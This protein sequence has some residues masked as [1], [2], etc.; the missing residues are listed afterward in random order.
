[1]TDINKYDKNTLN[2]YWDF[3]QK[4]SYDCYKQNAYEMK[5]VIM[6][7]LSPSIAEMYKEITDALAFSLYREVFSDKKNTFLYAVYDAI[8]MGRKFYE[9]CWLKPELITPLESK[10][11]PDYIAE[12][13]FSNVF[14]IEDDFYVKT[15]EVLDT[16]EYDINEDALSTN[17]FG[18]KM[19]GS[20]DFDD[21]Y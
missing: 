21:E 11:N 12:H 13:N 19:T 16:C 14:P 15:E 6:K 5:V 2:A 9:D 17:R 18:K 1:M 20:S 4:L 10:I 3:V 7:E 8:S